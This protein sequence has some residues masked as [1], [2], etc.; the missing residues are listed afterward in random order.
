MIKKCTQIKDVILLYHI[1]G[2]SFLNV[3]QLWRVTF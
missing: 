1:Y 2:G 3:T